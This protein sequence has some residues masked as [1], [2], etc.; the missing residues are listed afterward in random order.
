M[1]YI[2]VYATHMRGWIY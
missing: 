1:V 2:I